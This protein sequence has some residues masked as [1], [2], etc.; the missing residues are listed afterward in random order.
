[1]TDRAILLRCRGCARWVQ[2]AEPCGG[3]LVVGEQLAPQPLHDAAQ[4]ARDLHLADADPLADLALG[5]LVDVAQSEHQ[6]LPLGEPGHRLPQCVAQLDGARVARRD[7]DV[8]GEVGA[9]RGGRVEGDGVVAGGAPAGLVDLGD[10]DAQHAGELGVVGVAVERVPHPL[11]LDHQAGAQ[12]LDAARR[13]HRPAVV[14]EPALQL[15]GDGGVGEGGEPGPGTGPVAADGLDEGDPSHLEQVVGLDAATA[16]AHREA[17]GHRAGR[18]APA[19]RSARRARCRRRCRPAS[20]PA[21]RCSG[22]ARRGRGAA[23]RRSR[24]RWRGPCSRPVQEEGG[25]TVGPVRVRGS[26]PGDGPTVATAN[27]GP[28]VYQPTVCRAAG[29]GKDCGRGRDW[30]GQRLARRERDMSINDA[31]GTELDRDLTGSCARRWR[32]TRSRPVRPTSSRC[33]LRGASRRACSG[34]LQR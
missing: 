22:R 5:Q 20:R 9:G 13:A 4:D 18:P 34:G 27:T 25:A 14:A 31:I 8:V 30:G 19:A 23:R 33:L 1:M 6:A 2:A 3:Q 21:R 17:V 24:Q 32:G 15:A 16:V 12:L 7:E 10:G 28:G 26:S 11:L 29:P